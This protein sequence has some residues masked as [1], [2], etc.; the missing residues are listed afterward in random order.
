MFSTMKYY[1]GKYFTPH[2][3]PMSQYFQ[4]VAVLETGTCDAL[5][6]MN[7]KV[8]AEGCLFIPV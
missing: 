6:T 2:R 8:I 5:D 7:R 4:I 3:V 1:E